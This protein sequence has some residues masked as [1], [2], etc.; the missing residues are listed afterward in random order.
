MNDKLKSLPG[1][2]AGWLAGWQTTCIIIKVPSM[3]WP[4]ETTRQSVQ[5]LRE[6]THLTRRNTRH[7]DWMPYTSSALNAAFQH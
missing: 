5:Q 1:W 6:L 7:K 2:L 3:Q 4:S